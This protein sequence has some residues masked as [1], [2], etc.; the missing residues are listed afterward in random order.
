[1][2]PAPL[3][4]IGMPVYNG[5]KFIFEAI[6]ALLAQSFSNFELIISDNASTDRTEEICRDYSSKDERIRFIR[7]SN[8]IGGQANFKYVLDEAKADCFMWAAADDSSKPE[9]IE[10]LYCTLVSN[11][12][13]VLV[14]SD[15]INISEDGLMLGVS[16]LENIRIGDVKDHWEKLRWRFFDN[17]TTNIYFC[18]YGL[19]RTNILRSVQMNYKGMVTHL[20]GSEIPFLAQ[21]ALKGKVASI[22]ESLKIYRKHDNSVYHTEGN[23]MLILDRVKNNMN[24]C[25]CLLHITAESNLDLFDKVYV[26]TKTFL[27]TIKWVIRHLVGQLLR[28]TILKS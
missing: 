13:L 21:I 27:S 14:M 3:V 7:Q 20:A 8:N 6:D 18:I 11:P 2:S 17:P 10:R 23:R 28:K 22:P 5:E 1:M 4:S 9:F 26:I 15:V 24:I 25:S 12:E 19:F 16:E